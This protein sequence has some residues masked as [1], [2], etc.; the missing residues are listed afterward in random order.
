M[1]KIYALLVGINDYSHSVGKLRGCI[2]DVD[3]FNIF[4]KSHY[5]HSG[6]AVE[7]LKDHDATRENIIRQFR[8]HLCRASADDVVVFQY[9][10]HGARSASAP[11]FLEFYNSGKDEGLV[12]IDSREP[13]GLDLADKELAVLISE[14]AQNNRHIT[15][16]LDCCHSGSGTRN[17][18][19]FDG[20]RV[21]MTHERFKERPIESYIGGHYA[22]MHKRGEP[23]YIP[24]S[25][26]ILLAACDRKQTAKEIPEKS[27]VFT[28]SLLEVLEAEQG[29]ISYSGLFVRT[30]TATRNRASNQDPQ[31]ETFANFNA[32]DGFLGKDVAA[33]HKRARVYFDQNSWKVECGAMHGI[34]T[35][36]GT[37]VKLALYNDAGQR[38]TIGSARI[39]QV[40]P[41]TSLLKPE[42]SADMTTE[43]R[44]EITSLP[45]APILVH[46]DGPNDWKTALQGLLAQDGSVGVELS[47]S[48]NHTR[49]ALEKEDSNLILKE[50]DMDLLIQGVELGSENPV[51]HISSIMPVLK[52]VMQWERAI[53]VQNEN[54]RMSA[55]LVDCRFSEQVKN[56]ESFEHDFDN[57]T[58]DYRQIGADWQP[59]RGKFQ[60]RNNGR[61]LL[62]YM[63]VYFSKDYGIQVLRNDQIEPGDDYVTIWGD[64]PKLFL[65][66]DENENESIESFKL[67]VSNERVDEFL[68]DQKAMKLGE[69][70]PEM[71]AIS[72]VDPI[73]KLGENHDWFAHDCRIRVV[74][75]Q[76]Q[77]G[78]RD[79][80][81]ASGKIKIKGHDSVTGGVCLGAAIPSV[82][83]ISDG[84]HF[85][86][87]F[88]KQ[89]MS[90]LDFA[91]PATRGERENILE[92]T[93]IKNA[94]DLQD[95]P[96][97]LELDVDL[98]K[99]QA[100]IPMAFDGQHFLLGGDA[101]QD[102]VGIT[103]ISIDHLYD[104]PDN[105]R[106]IGG[107]LKLYFFKTYLKRNTTKLRWVDFKSDGTFDRSEDMVVQKVAAAKNILLL[108]HGILGDTE[109]IAQGIQAC[110][111]HEQFDL[112]L[113]YDYENL[114][115]PIEET[116]DSLKTRLA[117]VGLTAGDE[118]R[119]TILAHSMG[120]LVSRSYI[121]QRGGDKVVDHLVLCGT[122]NHGSP[123][124]KVD[125]AR[126]ILNLL[127]VIAMNFAPALVPFSGPFLML[128]NRSQKL[129]QSIEQMDPGSRFLK[130]LNNSD[131]PELPYTI[132]AGDIETYQEPTDQYFAN[133]LA[134]AG[135]TDAFEKLFAD[136]PND[137]AVGVDSI[138][139]IGKNHRTRPD[140][141]PVA[142]H[143]LN[144]F[145]SDTGQAALKAVDWNI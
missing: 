52:H 145:S 68:L 43:Y 61:Q 144:Y 106:S 140:F 104:I 133:L 110:T 125:D 71:R 58:L 130:I 138:K 78:K 3:Q 93:D 100:I 4:L 79:V 35:D 12:C 57:L 105:R 34:P 114:N 20:L 59:I 13:G 2:N 15:V 83:S 67:I 142:C 117:E 39:V 74:R 118:K 113:T 28:S 9:C 90:L 123:F 45:V 98:E 81:L 128:L 73:S 36:P 47:D 37:A 50:R 31:F 124:G 112:V 115:T 87:V 69:I 82:R 89:E 97:A 53:A 38:S 120:G 54:T 48:K 41:A 33:L 103:H 16:L 116:A 122:P 46:F 40:G 109:A 72:D 96:I 108:I 18:A 70:V 32:A 29:S 141:N 51:A 60:L 139:S 75:Q 135:K 101:Y 21:R 126:K 49:Y 44:A 62:H 19:A 6:L 88:E 55:E 86:R 26:H 121:E 84:E 143:H 25:R 11:E 137:I 77:I 65:Y 14:V 5:N 56:E 30:R 7:M 127:T 95:N 111:I 134:K 10:G 136:K 63:L 76:N 27:G 132:L 42:F 91:E 8:S 23:L 1:S 131:D 85:S 22:D 99:D 17:M 64:D 102:D 66:L 107:A 24:T 129:T 94:A 80:S 119:L 92:L